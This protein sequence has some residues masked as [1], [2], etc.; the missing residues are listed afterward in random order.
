MKNGIPTPAKK[1][2]E[3]EKSIKNRDEESASKFTTPEV[4]SVTT[5]IKGQFR[6]T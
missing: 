2:P 3:V 6:N 4:A 1:H 5:D